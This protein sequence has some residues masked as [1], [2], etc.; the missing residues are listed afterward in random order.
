VS[1]LRG[2]TCCVVVNQR[3]VFMGMEA[4]PTAQAIEVS[5]ECG[6][7]NGASEACRIFDPRSGRAKQNRRFG[8]FTTHSDPHGVKEIRHILVTVY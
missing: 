6:Y 8:S 5:A 7:V 2:T 4:A 1:V 3:A